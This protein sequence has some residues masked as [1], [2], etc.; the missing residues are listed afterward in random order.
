[1]STRILVYG[2]CVSRDTVSAMPQDRIRIVDYIARQSLVSAYS[3][4]VTLIPAPELESRFQARQAAGDFAS[5]LPSALRRTGGRVDLILW[6]LTDERLGFYVLP[7]DTAVT[8]SVDLI[9]AGIDGSIAQIASLISFGTDLHFNL[10]SSQLPRL[11]TTVGKEH[12]AARFVLIAPPWAAH[13]ADGS[14]TPSSF[15]MSAEDGNAKYERYLDEAERRGI[16]IIGRD[17]TDPRSSAEHVWGEAPF[18]YAPEV[19]QELVRHLLP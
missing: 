11:I 2:S 6:D 14:P 1:M 10:W 3:P 12:P 15:G 4:P 9:A 13:S 16:E 17:I 5:S 19:Y 18:H 7:D 8:R